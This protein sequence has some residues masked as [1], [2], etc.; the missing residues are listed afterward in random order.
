MTLPGYPPALYST[1][2]IEARHGFNKSTLGLFIADK[3]KEQVLFAVVGLPLLAGFLKIMSW[4]G[5]SFV[6]WLMGFL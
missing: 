1:F 3:I 5:D 4:A 2:V 6:G